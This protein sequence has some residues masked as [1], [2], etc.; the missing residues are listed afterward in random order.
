[1]KTLKLLT[2]ICLSILM[3]TFSANN[4]YSATN[5]KI[6]ADIGTK[7]IPQG[8][9]FELKLLDPINTST[10]AL[11]DEFSLMT[12]Q[13]TIIDKY[14]IIPTGSI[15]RGSVQKVNPKRMLSKGASIYLD[16]DHVVSPTGK[17][18]PLSVGV[19]Y[20]PNIT[21]D[22]GIGNGQNYGTAIKKNAQTTVNIVKV[23]T[24]WG[25]ETGED[26]LEGYPKYV[27]T[28]L[29]AMVSAPAAGI[30]FLGDAVIDLFKKGDDISLNQGDTIKVMLLKPLDIPIN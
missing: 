14:I 10:M 24:K 26:V 11:G 25:W 21:L 27:L 29:A 1:M 30:Y 3:T 28:P 12:M 18:I 7:R 20:R 17:Q 19:C 16:F 2:L 15:I 5:K 4:A 22:G 9:I 13:D 8:T 23:S 6:D